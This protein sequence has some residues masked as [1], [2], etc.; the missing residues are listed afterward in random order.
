MKDQYGV[1]VTKETGLG[2]KSIVIHS[3]NI[4]FIIAEK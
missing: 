1:D 2:G 3:E 4:R